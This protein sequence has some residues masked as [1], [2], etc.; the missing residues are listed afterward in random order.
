MLR[1]EEIEKIKKMIDEGKTDYSIGKELGHSPNTINKVRIKYQNSEKIVTQGEEI[2]LKNPIDQIRELPDIIDNIIKTGKL[3]A[4]DK[5][6]W[7]IIS[8]NIREIVREDFDEKQS[9]IV[10]ATKNKQNQIWHF[11]LNENYV[12]KEEVANLNDMINEKNIIINN[13][14]NSNAEKD[15]QLQN[16]QYEMLKQ[17]EM[18]Y[19]EKENFQNQ[20]WHLSNEKIELETKV[21][22]LSDYIGNYLDDAG[23]WEREY[24]MHE[25]ENIKTIKENKGNLSGITV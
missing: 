16:I 13:L 14:R 6:K 11:I 15:I 20:I 12:E 17:K 3:R 24:L 22:D 4:D 19:G 8:K 25:K 9:E 7:Q 1:D 18:S 23:R 21:G 10:E 2:Y 5:K